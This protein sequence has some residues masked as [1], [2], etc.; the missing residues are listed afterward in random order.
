MQGASPLQRLCLLGGQSINVFIHLLLSS[1]A[2]PRC[3]GVLTSIVGAGVAPGGWQGPSCRGFV[4]VSCPCRGWPDPAAAVLCLPGDSLESR[5][6]LCPPWSRRPAASPTVH[7][8]HGRGGNSE[9][10]QGTVSQLA[11]KD[12]QRSPRKLSCPG[13]PRLHLSVSRPVPAGPL[14]NHCG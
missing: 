14:P 2:L 1:A 6:A 8:H 10:A 5:R 7:V 12:V 4:L 9:K 13:E 3:G 11:V